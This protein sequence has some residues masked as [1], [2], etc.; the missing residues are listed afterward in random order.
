MILSL[1]KISKS[2]G[3]QH[4]NGILSHS[5]NN[6]DTLTGL[7]NDLVIGILGTQN[8]NNLRNVHRLI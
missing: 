4:I 8:S 5:V 2:W 3:E 1:V 7:F 6:N